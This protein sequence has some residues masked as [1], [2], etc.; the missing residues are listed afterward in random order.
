MFRFAQDTI[1]PNP[2]DPIYDL[3]KQIQQIQQQQQPQKNQTRLALF[4]H[5]AKNHQMAELPLYDDWLSKRLSLLDELRALP[6]TALETHLRII[7]TPE[8]ASYPK[9]ILALLHALETPFDLAT[10]CLLLSRIDH[11]RSLLLPRH[12]CGAPEAFQAWLQ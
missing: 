9:S 3:E 7:E 12:L 8:L 11:L 4:Y 5:D 1:Y 6:W 2:H 10:F